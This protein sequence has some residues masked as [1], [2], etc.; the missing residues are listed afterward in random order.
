[1]LKSPGIIF[2]A[3]RNYHVEENG[4]TLETVAHGH[5]GRAAH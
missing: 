2:L 3:S 5:A 1:M 4:E